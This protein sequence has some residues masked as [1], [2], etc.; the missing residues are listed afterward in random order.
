M[1]RN[2]AIVMIQVLKKVKAHHQK[3][4][5]LSRKKAQTAGGARRK[6]KN[7]SA[8]SLKDPNIPASAPDF[9]KEEVLRDLEIRRQRE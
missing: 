5:K 8:A 2:F 1:K 6:K 4:A 3:Q 9:F 7:T